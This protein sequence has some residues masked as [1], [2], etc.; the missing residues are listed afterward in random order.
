MADEAKPVATDASAVPP[1]DPAEAIPSRSR[2][3]SRGGSGGRWATS[4]A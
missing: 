4:S 2:L 1:A 3:A